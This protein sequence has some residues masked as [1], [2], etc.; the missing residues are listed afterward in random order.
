MEMDGLVRAEVSIS[1]Q[2][3]GWIDP[4]TFTQGTVILNDNWSASDAREA[5]DRVRSLVPA[6]ALKPIGKIMGYIGEVP[7]VTEL[8]YFKHDDG[9]GVFGYVDMQPLPP[10]ETEELR[11]LKSY[12]ED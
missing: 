3:N 6:G 5:R 12:E 7:G 2:G 9:R 8:K 11:P 4:Q 10:S 1:T